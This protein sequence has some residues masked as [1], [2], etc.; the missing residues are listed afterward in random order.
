MTVDEAIRASMIECPDD[1][2]RAYANEA[3]KAAVDFGVEGLVVQINYMLANMRIWRGDRAKE[4][5]LALRTYLKKKKD[6]VSID[7]P[8]KSK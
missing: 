1:K 7:K 2:A 6:V 5:K 8:K 4:V 3:M